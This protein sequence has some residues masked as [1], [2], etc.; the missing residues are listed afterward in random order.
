MS[1]QVDPGRRQDLDRTLNRLAAAS[2]EELF[3]AI[4]EALP[5]DAREEVAQAAGIV[6]DKINEIGRRFFQQLQGSLETAICDTAHYCRHKGIYTSIIDTAAL[7]QRS[8]VDALLATH[9][10]PPQASAPGSKLVSDLS[11]VV[12]KKGLNALCDC[13]G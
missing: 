12:L 1:D 9:G 8:V 6:P 5:S 11:A 3:A 4:G 13:P 2:E 7:V 10:L